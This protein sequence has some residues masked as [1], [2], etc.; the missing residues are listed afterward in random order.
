M[1]LRENL[2]PYVFYLPACAGI[3]F[4][5]VCLIC[6]ASHENELHTH[7]HTHNH[8]GEQQRECAVCFDGHAQKRSCARGRRPGD[9]LR[10]D[11]WLVGAY[12]NCSYIHTPVLNAC[13][14]ACVRVCV[15]ACV[16]WYRFL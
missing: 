13:M 5:V 14:R 7:T 6:R 16:H 9:L 11:S 2:R 8:W 4:P 12:Y 1:L 10:D 15:R 3:L